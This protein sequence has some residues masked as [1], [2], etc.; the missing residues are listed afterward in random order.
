MYNSIP[1]P[2][3][4]IINSRF[5]NEEREYIF[6]QI[7]RTNSVII[8][9]LCS[10][11]LWQSLAEAVLEKNSHFRDNMTIIIA[12]LFL[13][14]QPQFELNATEEDNAELVDSNLVK[15]NNGSTDSLTTRKRTSSVHGKAPFV[16]YESTQDLLNPAENPS[17][18]VTPTQSAANRNNAVSSEEFMESLTAHGTSTGTPANPA[19]GDHTKASAEEFFSNVPYT[20]VPG[21]PGSDTNSETGNNGPS[22]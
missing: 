16:G 14:H 6:W 17:R 4:G 18:I 15:V 8:F 10:I 2:V 3:K 20:S 1:L 9:C 12:S 19:A 11:W 5:A 22:I 21:T 7:S 13:P